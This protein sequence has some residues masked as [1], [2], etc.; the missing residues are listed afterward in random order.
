MTKEKIALK[1][2]LIG[3]ECYTIRLALMMGIKKISIGEVLQLITDN[4]KSHQS[5][6]NWC[7]KNNQQLFLSDTKK[8]LFI[9]YIKRQL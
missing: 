1:L 5:I 8:E 3:E 9:Y 7:R 6:F 4:P 2:E